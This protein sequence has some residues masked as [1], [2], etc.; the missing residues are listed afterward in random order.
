MRYSDIEIPVFLQMGKPN[1]VTYLLA[2]RGKFCKISLE[3]EYEFSPL[4]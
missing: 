1:S 3:T 2:S 4:L